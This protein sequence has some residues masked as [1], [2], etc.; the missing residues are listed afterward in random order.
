MEWAIVKACLTGASHK[1]RQ[2]PCQD[3][4]MV[5]HLSKDSFICAVS[6]GHGSPK[7]PYSDEGAKAAVSIGLEVIETLVWQNKEEELYPL[8]K[9]IKD[10]QLPK[11]IEKKWKETINGIHQKANRTPCEEAHQLYQ[12]YGCTLIL[13][14]VTKDFLFAM[15]IGDGDLLV[16]DHEG[17]TKWL[18]EPEVQYGTETY[19]LCQRKSWRHF[20]TLLQVIEAGHVPAL[21][22]ISTDGYAN[23]FISSADFLQIG[24]DY[25]ALCKQLPEDVLEENLVKW[26]EEATQ[27]GSGDDMT[28]AAIYSK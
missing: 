20:K 4:I 1:A 10:L 17:E 9:S 16:V 23:S 25:L 15:Q 2:M 13:L 14:W 7:C 19:S 3:A 28:L 6:D 22:L 8:M 5:N 24:K 26:L 12:L 18:I 27:K 21:F 11:T